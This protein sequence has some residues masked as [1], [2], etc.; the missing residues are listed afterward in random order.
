MQLN[1][2]FLQRGI[3]LSELSQL[4]TARRSPGAAEV[5]QDSVL[6]CT[7]VDASLLKRDQVKVHGG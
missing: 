4:A 5:D 6:L 3:N 2:S 7:E 1:A